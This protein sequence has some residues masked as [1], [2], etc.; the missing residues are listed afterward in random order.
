MSWVHPRESTLIQLRRIRLNLPSKLLSFDQIQRDEFWPD[1]ECRANHPL[2]MCQKW[3]PSMEHRWHF[4]PGG[5]KGHHWQPSANLVQTQTKRPVK[6]APAIDSTG[7]QSCARPLD[8]Q[9]Y[10]NN[11]TAKPQTW[12]KLPHIRGLNRAAIRLCGQ[13]A[14][15]AR[16]R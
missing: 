6:K 10:S 3:E 12:G 4:V 14:S 1:R 13:G 16:V 8:S 11:P 2:Q 9:R 5:Q 7:S 15:T